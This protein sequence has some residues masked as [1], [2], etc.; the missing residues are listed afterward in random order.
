[1]E[2]NGEGNGEKNE[3]RGKE[4]GIRGACVVLTV[5]LR[6]YGISCKCELEKLRLSVDFKRQLSI[7]TLVGACKSSDMIS[8]FLTELTN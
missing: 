2:R 1:M 5:F 3:S 4:K 8:S 7:T 6:I